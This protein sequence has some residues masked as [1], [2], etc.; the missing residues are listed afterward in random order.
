MQENKVKSITITG[1]DVSTS[2]SSQLSIAVLPDNASKKSVTWSVS[3]KLI[4]TIS[5]SALLTAS[6]GGTVIVTATANDGSGI[7]AIKSLTVSGKISAIP[8]QTITIIGTDITDGKAK[9][10]SIS[11]LPANAINKMVS[12]EVSSLAAATIT[13]DGL[14]T[15]KLNGTVTIIVNA[16]DGSG[17]VA[18]LQINVSGITTVFATT[19]RAESILLWQRN[20]GGRGKAVPDLTQYSIPQT[21]VQVAAALA[22]KNNTDT[23]IDN[24]HVVNELRCLLADYNTTQKP[25]YLVAAEKAIDFLLLAQYDNGGWPQYYPDKSFIDTK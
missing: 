10:F 11:I 21:A 20:N 24:G 17:K 14:L 8:V 16:T 19:V 15:P 22:S 1:T 6:A 9:Q 5:S 3:D 18:Q 25:N 7:V 2:G 4:A 23:T 13:N 12:W